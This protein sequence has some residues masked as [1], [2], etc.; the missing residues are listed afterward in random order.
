M[1]SVS[2]A[3]PAASR[4]RAIVLVILLTLIWGLFWPIMKVALAEIPI[5]SYRALGA[6]LGA[7][8]MF[9]LAKFDGLSLKV[10]PS[11]RW[12]LVFAGL[13]NVTGWFWLSA[14]G[15]SLMPAGRAALLA[16]TWP[17]W[18]FLIAMPVLG[19]RPTLGRVLGLLLGLGGIGVLASGSLQDIVRAPAGAAAIIAAAVVYAGGTVLQKR[20]AWRTPVLT[21]CAWQL[22]AG[23]VPLLFGAL[24]DIRQV[25][26]VS[27][28]AWAATAY[29]IIFGVIF[30]YYAW[31]KVIGMLSVATLS[32]STLLVPV[33]G[34]L[35][36]A[37]LLGE[38]L[39]AR[40]VLAMV[41]IAGALTT[42]RPRRQTALAPPQVG[43]G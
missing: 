7:A 29:T 2:L 16:Y 22:L 26:A 18:A 10:A 40:E 4:R 31:F 17:L 24:L 34:V 27:G 32:L 1:T 6:G 37:L 15:V 21:L 43:G 3:A 11:D 38:R 30:G 9:A 12:P 42:V 13:L 35:S 8:G 41:L 39:G 14:V 5:F 20:V 19:D 28:A 23:T 36:S 33:I 25:H